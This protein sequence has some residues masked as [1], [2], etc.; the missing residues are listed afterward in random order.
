VRV[1]SDC[2]LCVFVT[3]SQ[4]EIPVK[5][6]CYDNQLEALLYSLNHTVLQ[7]LH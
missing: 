4:V 5:G 2:L 6:D 3:D 7:V 1:N